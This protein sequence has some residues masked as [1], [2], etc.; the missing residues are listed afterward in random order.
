MGDEE[1]K[2]AKKPLAV[3]IMSPEDQHPR[4]MECF[5]KNLGEPDRMISIKNSVYVEVFG[6]IGGGRLL[7]LNNVEWGRGEKL[8]MQMIPARMSLDSIVQYVS[9]ELKLNS[10]TE[11]HIKDRHGNGNLKRRDDENYRAI[12]EDP[13]VGRDRSQ[14]PGSEEGKTCSG[15]EY[16]TGEDHEDARS[17][18]FV[19]H[20]TKA[21]GHDKGKW[22]K[23]PPRQENEPRK[24]GNPPLSFTEYRQETWYVL[25]LLWERAIP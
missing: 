12:Q 9:A 14:D 23:A 22:R 20:N 1:K 17:F 5:R 24:T 7:R 2:R 10:K 13:T 4:I 11:A 18:A 25:G 15:W 3:R 8:R 16:M 19:A 6:D 21:Y